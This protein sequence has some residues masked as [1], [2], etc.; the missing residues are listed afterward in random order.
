MS[1]AAMRL[2]YPRSR[3]KADMLAMW[4]WLYQNPGKRKKDY[5]EVFLDRAKEYSEE[6]VSIPPFC[7]ACEYEENL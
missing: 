6:C 5:I 1:E 2:S 3:M 4:Y 7:P